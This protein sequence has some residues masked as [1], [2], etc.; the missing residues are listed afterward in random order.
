MA[1]WEC[2]GLCGYSVSYQVALYQRLQRSPDGSLSSLVTVIRIHKAEVGELVPATVHL[3]DGGVHGRE[4]DGHS[5]EHLVKILCFSRI[6]LR[7]KKCDI[8]TTN[9]W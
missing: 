9:D 3:Q 6:R 2:L 7:Q 1:C 4:A 5:C 8:H